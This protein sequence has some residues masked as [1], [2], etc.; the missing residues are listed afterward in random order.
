MTNNENENQPIEGHD[1]DGITELDN[2]LPMWW[3]ATFLIA[4][5]YAFIYFLHIHLTPDNTIND[6]YARDLQVQ[7]DRQKTPHSNKPVDDNSLSAAV[8]SPEQVAKGNAKFQMLCMSCHGNVGQGGI[9]PNLT[10]A[11]WIHGTGQPQD[12]VKV[13]REGVLD[14]GMPAW[15]AVLKDD[16][17]I[18]VTAFVL[19]MKGTKPAG[20]KAPQ[21]TEIK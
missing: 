21:G 12:I 2:P 7:M 14:K 5:I 16:E 18:Q 3:L 1:Y 17:V 10:D 19:S 20:A 13:V 8:A 4:I 11:F 9:G 15:A 6:E